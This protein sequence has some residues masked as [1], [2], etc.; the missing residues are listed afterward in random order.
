MARLLERY[1]NEVAPLLGREFGKKN[2]LAVARIKK[3]V[4]N[5]GISKSPESEKHLE[6]ARRDLA[7]IAGQ[8]P[9]ITL[10]R[11]SVSGFKLREGDPI[12]LKATLRGRRMY[13]FLD[14]LISTAIPRIRDF[15]GL[16]PTS[17][18][19]AGNFTMG[20]NEQTVFPEINLDKV[21][22]VQGM[23]ITIVVSGGSREESLAL[24]RALGMPFR[25]DGASA[26]SG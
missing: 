6:E 21:E 13:E 12:G 5:M 8:R 4:I 18:D 23:D 10:A 19:A 20:L 24:L 2:V 7:L 1:R 22:H 17:F 26:I 3:I 9:I 16:S 14:R 15:R 25:K 11:A